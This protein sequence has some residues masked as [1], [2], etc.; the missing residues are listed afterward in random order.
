MDSSLFDICVK[1]VSRSN[2]EY[3]DKTLNE[4]CA[5]AVFEHN[6][7]E[8]YTSWRNMFIA[9]SRNGILEHVKYAF[10]KINKN[11]E[12]T[13]LE[14]SNDL[15]DA[16]NKSIIYNQVDI[17]DFLISEAGAKIDQ[18]Y[19]WP[20][21]YASKN[22]YVETVK[23]LIKHN[24]DF[25]GMF[26]FRNEPLRFACYNGH[27]EVVKL[28]IQAWEAEPPCA[29]GASLPQADASIFDGQNNKCDIPIECAAS[30]NHIDVVR[31]LIEEAGAIITD[32]TF[33]YAYDNKHFE[34]FQLLKSHVKIP[35]DI[36]N[37]IKIVIE[38]NSKLL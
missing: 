26:N 16:L 4:P 19:N 5:I 7:L 17:V 30:K 1:F 23:V 12:Y 28:L 3:S 33:K 35:L 15:Y 27:L 22:G 31:Y 32:K 11:I 14:R 20:I 34:L 6:M 37:T 36:V 8:R 18:D 9:A 10:K 29:E 25:K 21:R 24:A 2:M 38:F 13:A